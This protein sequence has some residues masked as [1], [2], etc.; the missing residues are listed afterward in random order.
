MNNAGVDLSVSEA[1][2]LDTGSDVL[3]NRFRLHFVTGSCNSVGCSVSDGNEK[4]TRTKSRLPDNV[5]KKEAAK[6]G[7]K[8]RATYH[9]ASRKRRSVDETDDQEE[10]DSSQEE[11]GGEDAID[12]TGK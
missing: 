8:H 7:K 4:K 5:G 11:V 1:Y 3:A 2:L 10:R 12:E 9:V 6:E